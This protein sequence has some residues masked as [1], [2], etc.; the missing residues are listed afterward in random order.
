MNVTVHRGDC[1][2]SIA[3][4][5]GVSLKA[6]IA[7]NPQIENPRLIQVGQQVHLPGARD[8][9]EPPVKPPS[10]P[11]SKP[12]AG[13]DQARAVA[14][15]KSIFKTQYRSPY[16]PTGPLRSANCGPTSLAMAIKAFGLEPSGLTPE[17]S[18]DRARKLMTGNTDDHDPTNDRERER[19]AR[20]AGLQAR[21]LSSMTHLDA[22]LAAGHMVTVTGD[23]GAA[24]QKV[25]AHYAQFKGLHSILVVGKASDG[26]YVVADPVSHSGPRLMTKQQ[27]QS[28]WA[29]G[30][31]SGTAVWR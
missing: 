17:Q 3:R 12:A 10:R 18:I 6:L 14:D 25:F 2:W 9:F 23:P 26:R 28:F 13:S 19:G 11:P 30:G 31:G 20:A 1:L 16:N 24:Y 21:H 15:P 7:A 27:L 22:E 8:E 29:D 5:H 4:A